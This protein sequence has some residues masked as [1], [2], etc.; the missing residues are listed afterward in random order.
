MEASLAPPPALRPATRER[1]G[2]IAVPWHIYAVLF[3]S[4]SVVL[5]VLWDISWHQTIG[6]D[7]F[8]SPPHMAIYV[9]GLVAGLVCG[10][11]VLHITFA[12]TPEERDASVRWW[13]YFHGPLGAWTCIWGSFAMLTSGPFDDW[14][15]NAYGLDVKILSPPHVVLALGIVAIQLGA[16]FMVVAL[17][18]RNAPSGLDDRR[19]QWLCIYAAALILTNFGTMVSEYT[20]RIFQHGTLFYQVVCGTLLIPLV[21]GAVASRLRWSATATAAIYTAILLGLGWIFQLFPAEPRLSP[22]FFHLDRMIP[23]Q[24]PLL[25]IVPAVALDLVTQ[26]W[27]DRK[28]GWA[29]A[30]VMAAVFLATFIAVQWPFAELLNSRWARNPFFGQHLLPYMIPE[31]S[32][33]GRGEFTNK[34]AV[35]Q[36]ARGL[37]I[38]L[39]LGVISARVALTRGE[40][41]QRIRR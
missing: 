20:W 8:W 38:A 9:G 16:L 19:L 25:L 7:T 34:P 3:A 37:A 41:M 30:A 5:G 27:G 23:P 24:Y 33:L 15:H 29:L 28:R 13:R 1:A 26:R 22:I 6:R 4:T 2:A 11:L 39:G 12:G 18:N 17:L 31:D 21:G 32:Y 14:W 10:W 36:M 40:W 35:L